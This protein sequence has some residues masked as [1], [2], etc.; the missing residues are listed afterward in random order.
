M[1]SSPRCRKQ[2]CS[3]KRFAFPAIITLLYIIVSTAVYLLF[4]SQI[5]SVNDHGVLQG[6][7]ALSFSLTIY[8]S[9]AFAITHCVPVFA[10]AAVCIN[11]HGHY[12]AAMVNIFTLLILPWILFQ[13]GGLYFIHSQRGYHK[14]SIPFAKRLYG[15][16]CVVQIIFCAVCYSE[17]PRLIVHMALTYIMFYYFISRVFSAH[18]IKRA[19]TA[20]LPYIKHLAGTLYVGVYLFVWLSI[21]LILIYPVLKLFIRDPHRIANIANKYKQKMWYVLLRFFPYGTIRWNS[22][23]PD[24]DKPAIVV[25][26]HCSSVDIALIGLLPINLRFTM[27]G[28]VLRDPIL[29]IGARIEGNLVVDS[30]DPEDLIRQCRDAF[31]RGCFVHFFPEGS[32][33]TDGFL[34]KFHKGAFDLAA[35]LRADILP[36]VLTDT[37]TCIPSGKGAWLDDFDMSYRFLK[38][39]TPQNFDYEPGGR[40]LMKHT[41]QIMAAACKEDFK[42]INTP[43]R[44]V[45]KVFRH[46][47]YQEFSVRR[48]IRTFLKDNSS[49]QENCLMTVMASVQR[50]QG[51]KSDGTIN[52]LCIGTLWGAV[53]LWIR[54]HSRKQYIFCIDTDPRMRSVSLRTCASRDRIYSAEIADSTDDLQSVIT[55]ALRQ[56]Q[57]THF[58]LIIANYSCL[59]QSSSRCSNNIRI[60]ISEIS[61]HPDSELL[62]FSLGSQ[63]GCFL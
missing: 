6:I 40:A 20:G 3:L 10:G 62:E 15:I 28:K 54:E 53:P 18:I 12:P 46:F 29:G 7:I 63:Q 57:D 17:T 27:K 36:L 13:T 56:F 50:Q 51:K 21:F 33:A 1:I 39:I 5:L 26:N 48:K 25:S 19:D 59:T 52:I 45:W 14:K 31:L 24:M 9:P 55:R 38:R 44:I 23:P 35:L 11:F 8:G 58:D 16:T 32:R 30:S 22:L 37:H 41:K 34:R 49:N 42:K 2:V 43:Q 47:R 61:R 60:P 4:L